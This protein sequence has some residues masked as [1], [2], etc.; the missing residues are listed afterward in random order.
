MWGRPREGPGGRRDIGA[1]EM[2][3]VCNNANIKMFNI[4][5]KERSSCS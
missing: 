4:Y 2:G 1:G 3:Q 5:K